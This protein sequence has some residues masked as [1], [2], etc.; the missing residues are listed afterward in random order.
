MLLQYVVGACNVEVS[1]KGIFLQKYGSLFGK[2]FLFDSCRD[3]LM[4]DG[5]LI[6]F[7]HFRNLEGVCVVWICVVCYEYRCCVLWGIVCRKGRLS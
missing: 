1:S 6:A 7:P 5:C 3:V 4:D 2:M